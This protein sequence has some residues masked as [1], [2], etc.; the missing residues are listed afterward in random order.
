LPGV[1]RSLLTGWGRTA[2]SAARVLTPAKAAEVTA[3]VSGVGAGG[4]GSLGGRGVVARGL[5]R[6]YGDAAQNA[7]GDVLLM[8]GL[9]RL[10]ALDVGAARVTVEP[11]VSLDWLMR[12]LLPLGLFPLVTPG[13]RQVTVGGAIASDIHGKNHH[14]DGSF[15]NHIESVALETP[16]LGRISVSPESQPDYFWATAGGMGL[17]GVMV[18]ATVRML[19]VETSMMQVD[20]TRLPDLDA[21]M[22]T[23]EESD[24]RYRYSVAW[25]DSLA[26]GRSLGRAVLTRGDHASA[27]DLPEGGRGERLAFAGG[28]RLAAPPWVPGGLLNGLTVAAFNE[29]W[30]RKAPRDRRD[31]VTSICAFFHPLD[32]VAGWNR[33][34]GPRGFVQYQFVVPFA[35]SDV[36]RL[37]LEELSAARCPSFLTVLKRF[38]PGNPGPLS[39]PM[40]GWTLALDLPAAI[41]GLARLL[42]RL[43]EQVVAAGGRVYLAKDSRMRPELLAA[44]YP[45]LDQ[46]RKIRDQLDPDNRLCS[47]LARR[48]WPLTRDAR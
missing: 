48:L 22:A 31:E 10:L 41:P 4:A 44:M 34:Y 33:I 11:G 7:G 3:A 47:D 17:T 19:A 38:G 36:V 16:A 20:T 43:D 39:F 21:V 35:R 37:V 26:R 30:F 28:T 29:A 45:E 5:G 15:A 8:T 1:E 9:D 25:V 24:D 42:D 23:M 12:T 40:P 2:P 27:A 6:S 32:G 18:S 14:G 46:W 13:T